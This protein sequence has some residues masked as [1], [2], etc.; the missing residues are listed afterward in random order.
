MTRRESRE[1][2]FILVFQKLF[3]KG[4]TIDEIAGAAAESGYIKP[5]NF[6]RGLAAGV[7][8]NLGSIDPLIDANAIDWSK[9]RL[10]KVSLSVLRLAL[11]EML[12]MDDIP[13]GASINEAV[14]ISKKFST[15]ADAAFVNGILG[16][17]ARAREENEN[18][19]DE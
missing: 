18:A 1:L 9:N 11:Y 12:F 8:E 17:V 6:A 13:V 10:S 14:E 16:T 7:Y 5:N 19:K 3:N 2:A 15:E 4:E